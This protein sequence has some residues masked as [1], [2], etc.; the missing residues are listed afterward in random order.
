MMN[1][2]MIVNPH[3]RT[4]LVTLLRNLQHLQGI[5]E[6]GRVL[7]R[8]L[9]EST[10]LVVDHDR[11]LEVKSPENVPDHARSVKRDEDQPVVV[12]VVLDLVVRS[13]IH[14]NQNR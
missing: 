1:C 2:Q 5:H 4:L 9:H 8:E 13:N 10:T 7:D 6:D 3:L 11:G 14:T 12:V